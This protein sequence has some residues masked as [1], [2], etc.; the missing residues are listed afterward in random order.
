MIAESGR[1]VPIE[2]KAGRAGRLPSV[3]QII[4]QTGVGRTIRVDMNLP[5]L[6]R[7]ETAV[8]A[9]AVSREISFDLVSYPT[10]VVETLLAGSPLSLVKV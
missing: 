1:I 7:V 10:Y 4:A 3:H 5:T 2:V 6:Q 9:P 8:R